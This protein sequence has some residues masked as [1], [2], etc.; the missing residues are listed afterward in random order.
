MEKR[1][2]R[3]RDDRMIWGVCGGIARYFDIDPVVV[4]VVAIV[5]LVFTAGA[6]IIAYIL[7]AIIVPL[8]TSQT[9]EPRE[10]IKENVQEI[11]QTAQQFGEDVRSTLSQ[12]S[13]AAGD[14]AGDRQRTRNLLGIVLIVGG[15]I[16]LLIIFLSSLRFFWWFNWGYLWPLI[17]IALGLLV[18]FSARRR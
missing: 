15:A 13:S 16:L 7:A 18:I 3:S 6:A 8:E 12:P 5:L 14:A 10:V 9:R 4:R 11:K 2:Y 17:L 1:L